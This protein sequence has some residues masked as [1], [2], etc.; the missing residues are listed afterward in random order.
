MVTLEIRENSLYFKGLFRKEKEIIYQ[1]IV[2]VK[3]VFWS[4]RTYPSFWVVSHTGE[5]IKVHRLIY[6]KDM[7]ELIEELQERNPDIQRGRAY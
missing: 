4:Q 1:D 2:E 6:M 3:E 5:R 7:D